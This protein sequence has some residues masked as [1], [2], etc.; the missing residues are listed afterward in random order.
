MKVTYCV[1][2]LDAVIAYELENNKKIENNSREIILHRI[3]GF[4]K[5]VLE[6]PTIE[7]IGTGNIM[8]NVDEIFDDEIFVSFSIMP[9]YDIMNSTYVSYSLKDD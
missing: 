9:M 6:D 1:Q 2:E 7:Y 5:K 8:M 3:F 4:M